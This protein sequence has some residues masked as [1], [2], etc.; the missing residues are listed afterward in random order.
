MR[1]RKVD[2]FK[3]D[4]EY[5]DV[6]VKIEKEHEDFANDM[7]NFIQELIEESTPTMKANHLTG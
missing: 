6:V 2:R 3:D 1:F 7:F 4:F 5:S